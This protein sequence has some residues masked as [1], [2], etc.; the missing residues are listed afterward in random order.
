MLVRNHLHDGPIIKSNSRRDVHLALSGER[1]CSG[2]VRLKWI[3]LQARRLSSLYIMLP[4]SANNYASLQ[5]H[6]QANSRKN[7]P[8]SINSTFTASFSQ[9]PV[10]NFII[11]THYIYLVCCGLIATMLLIRFTLLA[12]VLE[13]GAFALAVSTAFSAP[14]PTLAPRETATGTT[15]SAIEFMTT[16]YITIPGITN[17]HVTLSPQTI[18]IAVPTCIQTIT[19]DKN[20]YVS[21]GT[22]HALY[23]YYP[24][25]TAALAFSVIFG[26]LTIAHIAQA[27]LFKT[28]ASSLHALNI[29]SS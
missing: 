5:V 13:T 20:G 8:L 24:S 12:A 28:V 15:T 19:P 22:C 26:M 14:T 23:D 11:T 7:V 25:F 17:D 6:H 29:E 9:S 21:P 27:A 16:N 3:S 4:A 10:P 2:S 1:F 18:S